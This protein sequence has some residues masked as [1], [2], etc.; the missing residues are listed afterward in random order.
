MGQAAHVGRPPDLHPAAVNEWVRLAVIV[1]LGRHS[2]VS[3]LSKSVF[4]PVS[5]LDRLETLKI[6]LQIKSRIADSTTNSSEADWGSI[7]GPEGLWMHI[8]LRLKGLS[9]LRAEISCRSGC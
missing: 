7:P 9:F 3:I 1:L 8:S 4:L 2:Y 5:C 6:P